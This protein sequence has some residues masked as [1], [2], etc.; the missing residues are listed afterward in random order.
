MRS[1]SA[2]THDGVSLRTTSRRDRTCACRRLVH[3]IAVD[4]RGFS[5]LL[6]AHPE[7]DDVQEELEQILILRVAALHGERQERLASR[8]AMLGLN[9]ARGRWPGL[10]TLNGL[11]ASSI[12]NACMRCDMPKPVLPAMN[13]GTQPPLGVIDTTQPCSS[14]AWTEVVPAR[15]A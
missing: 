3:L 15:N 5:R 6:H 4:I 7:L 9:V 8:S 13:A 11:I 2:R 12:T 1:S 10:M 14:A